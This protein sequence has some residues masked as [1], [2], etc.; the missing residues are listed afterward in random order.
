MKLK[1]IMTAAITALFTLPAIASHCD[2][3]VIK[4]QNGMNGALSIKDYSASDHSELKTKSSGDTINRRDSFE[5]SA[6]SGHRSNGGAK[7]VIELLSNDGTQVVLTYALETRSRLGGGECHIDNATGTTSG[8][9]SRRAPT[10]VIDKTDG[11]PAA[12]TFYVNS[13]R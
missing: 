12:I 9:N 11:K 8:G 1:M 10:V 4:V 7:G 2:D 13:S 6:S 5:F 3:S